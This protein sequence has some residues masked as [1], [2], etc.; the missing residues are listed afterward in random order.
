YYFKRTDN[1]N[2]ENPNIKVQ[3]STDGVNFTALRTID[4]INDI[5]HTNY[6]QFV[7]ALP[8]DLNNTGGV[9]LRW[10]YDRDGGT[11][12]SA[13]VRLD[14]VQITVEGLIPVELTSFTAEMI[15][16]DI[17]LRWSTA[18][19]TENLGFHMFRSISKDDDYV[20]ITA[21]LIPGAGNSAEAHTYSYIDRDVKPG[22]SYYYKLADVDFNGIM[23]FH[24]PISVTLEALPTEYSLAQNFPNPFNPETNIRFAMKEAGEVTLNIYNL[25]GQLVRSLVSDHREAGNYSVMWNGA[26][27]S[28]RLV[29]SGIYIYKFEVNRFKDTKRMVFLK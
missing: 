22:N 27:N 23:E 28:G 9:T 1:V 25:Q 16:E 18:T 3:W 17:L 8:A 29:A 14:D 13:A 5:T 24:G 2:G 6:T 21:E 12:Q 10:E 4:V 15:S 20:K 19:E 7:D 11:R 26:D